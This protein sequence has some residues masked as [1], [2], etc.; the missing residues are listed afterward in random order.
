MESAVVEPTNFGRHLT[1]VHI[2]TCLASL[3]EVMRA[4]SY[5]QTK[6]SWRTQFQYES[7]VRDFIA[8]NCGLMPSVY[9]S[10]C[11]LHMGGRP[12][13]GV[14]LVS[15]IHARQRLVSTY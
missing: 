15:N 1:L 12:N 9:T 2:S 3:P 6:N 8:L 14:T 4:A 10:P 7:Y 5:K 13:H 11:S